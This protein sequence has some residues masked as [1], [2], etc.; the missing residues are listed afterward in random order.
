MF[1]ANVYDDTAPNDLSYGSFGRYDKI[2][3]KD[4]SRRG[5]E[6]GGLWHTGISL[7]SLRTGYA[8]FFHPKVCRG[9]HVSLQ[10]TLFLMQ[11]RNHVAAS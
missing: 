7:R 9:A 1:S 8:P 10:F 11:Q 5:E 6:S 4:S 2:E 3:D